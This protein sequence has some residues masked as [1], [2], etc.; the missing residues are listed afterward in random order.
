MQAKVRS[1][2][3]QEER[4]LRQDLSNALKAFGLMAVSLFGVLATCWAVLTLHN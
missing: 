4:V 2:W 3:K 1:P